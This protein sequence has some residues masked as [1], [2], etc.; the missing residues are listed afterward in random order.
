MST[1]IQDILRSDRMAA[2]LGLEV[3][4]AADG[5]ARVRGRVEPRFLNGHGIAHG[6]YL[7]ALMDMA[8]AMS[9]NSVMESVGIQYGFSVFRA[10]LEGEELIAESRMLHRGRRSMVCDMIVTNR[11]GRILARGQATALPTPR[12][13]YQGL[14]SDGGQALISGGGAV[15]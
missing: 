2:L 6:V 4:E 11:E 13:A 5:V 12:E 1:D 14:A 15:G 10:A 3:L 8:F 7:F 9:V